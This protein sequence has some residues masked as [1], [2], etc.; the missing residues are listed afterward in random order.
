MIDAL[1]LMY[2]HWLLTTSWLLAIGFFA[3]AIASE[4]RDRHRD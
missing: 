2:E 4:W 1:N 3:S